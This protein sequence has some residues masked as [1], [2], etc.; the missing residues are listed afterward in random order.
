MCVYQRGRHA[1]YEQNNKQKIL[2]VNREYHEEG[3]K[4]FTTFPK[5]T[6]DV[7]RFKKFR[8]QWG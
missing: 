5:N 1:I 6:P 2:V 8:G 7:G 3:V 4:L